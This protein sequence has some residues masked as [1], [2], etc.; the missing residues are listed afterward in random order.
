MTGK[1]HVWQEESWLLPFMYDPVMRSLKQLLP[2]MYPNKIID[3]KITGKNYD[4]LMENDI[5]IWVGDGTHPK[6]DNLKIKKIYVIYYNLEPYVQDPGYDEIWTYSRYMLEAHSKVFTKPMKFVPIVHDETLPRIQYSESK[7]PVNLTFI[8][9]VSIDNRIEK[10]KIINGSGVDIQAINNLWS[11]TDFNMFIMNNADIYL[12]LTKGATKALP[13]VRMNKLLSHKCII[14]SERTN[15]LDEELYKDIVFFKDLHE[16]G[17]FY[18]SL[19]SKSKVD[20]ES[21]AESAYQKF[22]QVFNTEKSLELIQT[23]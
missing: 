10:K 16:I 21:I 4:D 18:K 22:I 12:N 20:L 8:G 23:K 9:N 6:Y 17:D 14:I 7:L 2:L 5:L 11:H 15:E 19:V 3:I 1:I 13:S